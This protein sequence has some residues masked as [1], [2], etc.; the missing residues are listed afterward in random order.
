MNPIGFDHMRYNAKD[1]MDGSGLWINYL[2]GS[3]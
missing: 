1:I 3:T 2:V